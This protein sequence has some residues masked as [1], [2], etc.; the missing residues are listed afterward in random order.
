MFVFLLWGRRQSTPTHRRRIRDTPGLEE[1]RLVRVARSEPGRQFPRARG[2]IRRRGKGFLDDGRGRGPR[3][4][5]GQDC[6]PRRPSLPVVLLEGLVQADFRCDGREDLL[7]GDEKELVEDPEVRR[8]PEHDA[9]ETLADGHRNRRVANGEL[10][11]KS[12]RDRSGDGPQ[13]RPGNV[14]TAVLLGQGVAD[15]VLRGRS[16]LDQQGSEPSPG[17]SL[18][19]QRA[20]DAFLTDGAGAKKKDPESRHRS[21]DYPVPQNGRSR[22]SS[23]EPGRMR[24][25]AR[26]RSARPREHIAGRARDA[27][28]MASP[29]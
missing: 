8:V 21:G 11:R 9:D 19:R 7:S 4:L 27:R 16:A 1:R 29:C 6:E 12:R 20:V 26:T 14:R 3:E 28:H 24:P 10:G 5:F 13:N 2:E 18:D 25:P 17:E 15:L 22:W 23:G